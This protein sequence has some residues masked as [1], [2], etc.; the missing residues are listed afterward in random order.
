MNVTGVQTSA[1]PICFPT[2]SRSLRSPLPCQRHSL[3][4]EL[5]LAAPP[6]FPSQ[7]RTNVTSPPHAFRSPH[8]RTPKQCHCTVPAGPATRLTRRRLVPIRRLSGGFHG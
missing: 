1:L 3:L 4:V 7:I 5:Q 2:S 8:T 6:A